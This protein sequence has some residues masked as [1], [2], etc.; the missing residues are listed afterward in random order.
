MIGIMQ[1]RLTNSNDNDNLDWFP[2][3]EWQCEF[4]SASRIGFDYIELVIDKSADPRNPLFSERSLQKVYSVAKESN[5]CTPS[6]CVNSIINQTILHNDEIN[7]I[8]NLLNSSYSLGIK[9][10]ILPL[11][12]ASILTKLNFEK[13]VDVIIEISMRAVDLNVS[14][15]IE[16][17]A[18]RRD[19]ENII[20]NFHH[21]NNVKL[22]YDIGNMTNCGYNVLDD[23]DCYF[24]YIGHIHIK[25]KNHQGTNVRLGSGEVNFNEVL[26]Y[27]KNRKYNGDFTLET[28]RGS[29][30]LVEAAINLNYINQIIAMQ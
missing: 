6:C 15:L 18:N 27:L 23:L 21:L 5:I 9:K 22:V 14:V 10:I 11:F 1:G 29:D 25:D 3:E 8:V 24:D 30:A 19:M 17:N 4:L 28:A 7:R 16:V 2:F 12:E 26:Q 20:N 13:I